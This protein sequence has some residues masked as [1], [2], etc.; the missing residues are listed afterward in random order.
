MAFTF[1]EIKNIVALPQY[2]GKYFTDIE[3]EIAVKHNEKKTPE[4]YLYEVKDQQNKEIGSKISDM[5]S[6]N[7]VREMIFAPISGLDQFSSGLSGLNSQNKRAPSPGSTLPKKLNPTSIG[8][9]NF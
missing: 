3:D 7:P 2:E 8:G 1:D 4:E 5:I 6:G 9:R